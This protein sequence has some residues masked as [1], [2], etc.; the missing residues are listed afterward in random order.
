MKLHSLILMMLTS[1]HASFYSSLKLLNDSIRETYFHVSYDLSSILFGC[2]CCAYILGT[3]IYAG[4]LEYDTF[5]IYIDIVE[6]SYVVNFKYI[7][8]Y[9]SSYTSLCRATYKVFHLN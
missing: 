8:T 2:N 4:Y 3:Y 1:N 5:W 7:S 6:H 9:V